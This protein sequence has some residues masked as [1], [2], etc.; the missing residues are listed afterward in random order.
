[1]AA[2][3]N[4]SANTSNTG[5]PRLSQSISWLEE[6]SPLELKALEEHFSS[7]GL[8][9]L[10]QRVLVLRHS[11]DIMEALSVQQNRPNHWSGCAELL[12]SILSAIHLEQMVLTQSNWLVGEEASNSV[13]LNRP[14]YVIQ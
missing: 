4:S 3:K 10:Q 5:N 1:M 12:S 8:M 6:R 7:M 2:P 11:F 14:T 13:L 9:E